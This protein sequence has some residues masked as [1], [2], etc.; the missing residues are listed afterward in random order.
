MKIRRFF[1]KLDES[2]F[3]S[4]NFVE[5]I[6]QIKNSDGSFASSEIKI[7]VPDSWSQSAT[8]ILAQK[9]LRKAGVPDKVERV[10]EKDVP[11]WL[12]KSIPVDG[13]TFGSEYHAEQIFRRLAGCWT[14]WGWKSNVFDSENDAVVFFDECCYMLAHQIW[15]P[16]SPQWFNTGLYWAYGIEGPPQGHYYY[17]ESVGSVVPSTSAYERPQPHACFIQSVKDDLVGS[18][19]IMDLWVREARLYKYGSGTGSNF[20]SLRGKGEPLSGGGESSGLLSWLRIGDRSA[21]AIKS[22]GTTRRAAKMVILDCDHPDV[23]DFISW[24][25]TEQQKVAALI[26]GSKAIDAELRKIMDACRSLAG[27]EAF[28]PRTNKALSQSIRAARRS[29]V[30]DNYIWR[31]IQLAE[32][33]YDSLDIQVFDT[34]WEGEAYETVSGQQSN[35]SIG[36]TQE[37]LEAVEQGKEW[38]LTWRTDGSV[39][40]TFPAADLWDKIGY[41]AWYCGDPGL[42]FQTT[43]NEWHTCSADGPIRATNPC[44]EYAF[45]DDTAC[46]LAGLNLVAFEQDK[47]GFPFDVDAY[48][49]TVRIVTTVAEISIIMSQLPSAEIARKT[50]EYRTLGIG[51]ANLG[52]LL[53]R[54]GLPYDSDE[55][56]DF[57]GSLTAILTGEAYAQSARL[58]AELG[59]FA[60]FERNRDSMLRVIR[61]H[62]RAAHYVSPEEYEGLSVAPIGLG[63][64]TLHYLAEA[65]RGAWDQALFLGEKYG[66]RNAQVS[67]IAPTGTTGF[68]L[69]CDT[70]GI[71]PDFSLVK[72]KTLAGGGGFKIVNQSVPTALQR[73]GYGEYQITDI[74]DYLVG[75]AVLPVSAKEYLENL[76]FT[77]EMFASIDEMLPCSAHV[78]LAFTVGNI[79]RNALLEHTDLTKDDF[80]SDRSLL[81]L[82]GFD[83][84]A[85][86]AMNNYVCGTMTVEGAPHLKTSD[87]AVFDCSGRCGWLG[88][89][90][91]SPE[92]H[93]QMLGAVQ[94]F[95]S[96]AISKTV[97]VHRDAS[98]K[99]M[100]LAYRMA[101]KL[102]L[103]AVALYRD[104]SKLS[105]PLDSGITADLFEGLEDLPDEETSNV[106][107]AMERVVEKLVV[108]YM[109]ERRRLPE[110]RIG[111]TQKVIIQTH[112]VFL[113]TGLYEDGTVGEIFVDMHKEGAAFRSLMNCFSIA[114]SV[115]LQHGVPLEK[116][117]DLFTFTKFEPNGLVM[118]DRRIMQSTSIIDWIFRHLAVNYLGRDDLAHVKEV[119][120]QPGTVGEGS[121]P[122]W[123]EERVLARSTLLDIDPIEVNE[124]GLPPEDTEEC[125]IQQTYFSP[126]R[127]QTE[128]SPDPALEMHS[129][130]AVP[131][132]LDIA[133]ASGF[134]GD[135]CESCGGF[136][137]IRTGSC[138][139]C[140][141][142]KKG[143][144]CS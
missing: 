37:F 72:Y 123:N 60:A 13:A 64:G 104:G 6:S 109:S 119:D 58:A 32:Q 23:E 49:H 79:G 94:P 90:L 100:L 118:G 99:D 85:I 8:N 43:M 7:T 74:V 136:T 5:R 16:N 15:A 78:A 65:A 124:P 17:D 55:A 138:V 67:A 53:M 129:M 62:R 71:E 45:L 73:L 98:V 28:D 126:S 101:W 41:S 31:A 75:H 1:T 51:Y 121:E 88:T 115:G 20:S 39:V 25:T 57:A 80:D 93:L 38:N 117:V 54:L 137:L 130:P 133:R 47:E 76:G 128:I 4:I 122:S 11:L 52:A 81:E 140:V 127:S 19:G 113:R 66:Y 30:P 141:V 135:P 61:N 132:A 42:Q 106:A 77:K 56:R 92:G 82:L 114:I 134:E 50:W 63:H 108:R 2:P 97:N 107:S 22:G 112:K 26:A 70:T 89:R 125:L 95:V 91:I 110:R 36:V 120:L 131:S 105:Q 46:N 68:V 33:G 116:F 69:D 59:P 14:Y 40:R 111:H 3:S 143:S 29:F 10:E 87:Y 27:E 35:N 96:G 103:K 102:G 24:K 34:D 48:R 139:K 9:Y 18:G 83:K 144:S 44:S 142:C 21:G 12:S 86:K 84:D